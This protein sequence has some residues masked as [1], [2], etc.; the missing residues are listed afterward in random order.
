M[1]K[2]YI[3]IK[4][5]KIKKIYSLISKRNYCLFKNEQFLYLL[6]NDKTLPIYTLMKTKYKP[7][8][9]EINENILAFKLGSYLYV[10]KIGPFLITKL[11]TKRLW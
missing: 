9:V 10:F 2:S 11:Y 5:V 4:G 3:L 6:T 1:K 7:S 8:Y